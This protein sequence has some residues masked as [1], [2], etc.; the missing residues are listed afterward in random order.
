MV[1]QADDDSTNIYSLRQKRSQFFPFLKFQFSNKSI[2][3]NS[4]KHPIPFGIEIAL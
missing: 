4:F 2:K 1:Y 3:I